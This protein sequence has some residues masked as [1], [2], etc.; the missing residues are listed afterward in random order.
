MTLDSQ[1]A[2]ARLRTGQAAAAARN[3]II[4]GSLPSRRRDRL[5]VTASAP[6]QS[7][8]AEAGRTHQATLVGRNFAVA[9]ASRSYKTA[10][11]AAGRS[12]IA[13]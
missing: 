7:A 5:A 3:R 4:A 12:R 6:F 2:C 9:V 10:A 13:G 1:W 11:V 8:G